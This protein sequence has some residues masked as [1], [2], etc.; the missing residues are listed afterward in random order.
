MGITF[1][2]STLPGSLGIIILRISTD[3]AALQAAMTKFSTFRF[4]FR[5]SFSAQSRSFTPDFP[6]LQPESPA[7]TAAWPLHFASFDQ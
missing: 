7:N 6:S 2:H 3:I 4:L 1:H 5:N